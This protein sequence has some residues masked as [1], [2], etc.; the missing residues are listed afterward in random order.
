M[1]KYEINLGLYLESVL[2]SMLDTF[3]NRF[4]PDLMLESMLYKVLE[5]MF[6]SVLESEFN[7]MSLFFS[8]TSFMFGSLLASSRR[9]LWHHL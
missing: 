2:D 3:Q 5:S 6:D 4:T 9:H 7:F 1:L 8:T